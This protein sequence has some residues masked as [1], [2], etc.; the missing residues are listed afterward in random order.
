MPYLPSTDC[1]TIIIS[2]VTVVGICNLVSGSVFFDMPPQWRWPISVGVKATVLNW[3]Q[4]DVSASYRSACPE[5][6]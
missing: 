6:R 5:M 3:K 1:Q 2:V 4:V